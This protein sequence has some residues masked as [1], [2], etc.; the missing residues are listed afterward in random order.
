MLQPLSAGSCAHSIPLKVTHLARRAADAPLRRPR[1]SDCGKGRRSMAPCCP[2]KK[3]SI[4]PACQAFTRQLHSCALSPYKLYSTGWRRDTKLPGFLSCQFCCLWVC[5]ISQHHMRLLQDFSSL[6]FPMGCLSP[7]PLL[8]QLPYGRAS[9]QQE[10][11][12][13]THG[14]PWFCPSDAATICQAPPRVSSLQF[15]NGSNDCAK[16]PKSAG[17][18]WFSSVIYA[19][20]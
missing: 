8:W 14:T 20:V 10:G 5:D 1:G 7:A 3:S 13:V 11:E 4:P 18:P 19:C 12:D 2:L 6:P 9:P 16:R 15:P 17:F